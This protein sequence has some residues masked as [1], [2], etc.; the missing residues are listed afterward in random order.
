MIAQCCSPS[1]L[2]KDLFA[3]SAIIALKPGVPRSPQL[4]LLPSNNAQAGMPSS[5][6]SSRSTSTACSST[7][8]ARKLTPTQS[9]NGLSSS[10][11]SSLYSSSP[12]SL[13]A[14]ANWGRVRPLY[15]RRSRSLH[16]LQ[17]LSLASCSWREV[18]PHQHSNGLSSKARVTA[19]LRTRSRCIPGSGHSMGAFIARL[20]AC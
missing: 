11:R 9:H 18:R 14:R 12:Y 4:P 15:S 7:Q 19:R 2:K 10:P 3:W 17:S 6:S 20:L 5:H 13:S 8:H 1:A 16:S